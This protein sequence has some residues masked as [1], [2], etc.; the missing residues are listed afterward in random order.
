MRI[1][2][3]PIKLEDGSNIV[4]WRNS[5]KV[6]A[7]CFSKIPVTIESNKAFFKY[8]IE[9][10]K[11][12]QFIVERIDEDYG[13]ASYPIATIYLKDLDHEN[14][15]CE[16]CIF[17]S[18]D[19]EWNTESQS[20]A[21][22]QLLDIAFTEYD[23]HKVYTFVFKENQDEIDLMKRAGLIEE[24]ILKQEAVNNEGKYV[25]VLRMAI[26][27]SDYSLQQ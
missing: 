7:H 27:S 19:Q 1:Y 8:Y 10:E 12:K 22:R 14:H 25:D 2:L 23:M 18:D 11:Y 24:A 4:K 6:K 16:L 21:I 3:R 9:T 13:V 17:T 26:L 15:R 20:I 5:D